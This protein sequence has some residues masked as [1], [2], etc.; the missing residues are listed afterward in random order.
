MSG[1]G[2]KLSPG[3]AEAIATS[4][5]AFGPGALEAVDYPKTA[6]SWSC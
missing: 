4:T 1:L 3:L 5:V 2:G 6:V